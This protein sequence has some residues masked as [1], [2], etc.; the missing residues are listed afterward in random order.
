MH[1]FPFNISDYRS[2]TAHL[3]NEQDLTYRRLI[4]MYYDTE[5][6]IPDDV[7]WVGRRIR[8]EPAIV[9]EVLSDMFQKEEGGW[10]HPRCEFEIERYHQLIAKNT[11]NGMKGGRPKKPTGLPSLTQP[12]PKI[13]LTKNYELRTKNQEPSQYLDADAS[14]S[15]ALLHD[16]PHKAI[17]KSFKEHLPHLTQPRVWDGNR[18]TLLKNRWLQASKPSDFSEEGYKTQDEGLQWWSS[19]IEYIAK[20]TTLSKGFESK[21]RTWK[22]DLEW[23][24]RPANFQKIIDGNYTK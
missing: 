22:P 18:K 8:V 24:V 1:Y 6:P 19:L 20:R 13:T 14:K 2:A 17:L 12:E 21:D 3:S 23:I 4:E 5:Q 7:Q 15:S 16:C 10:T 9:H 11:Q